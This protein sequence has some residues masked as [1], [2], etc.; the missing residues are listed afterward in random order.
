MP[1]ILDAH[2]LHAIL[3]LQK[4]DAANDRYLAG[5]TAP[6]LIDFDHNQT[7]I[8]SAQRWLSEYTITLSDKQIQ[9][10]E[11]AR[12]LVDLCNAYPDAGAY[13]INFRLAANE[14]IRWLLAG[15]QASQR[16][17]NPETTQAHLG[18][19]GLAFYELGNFTSAIQYFEDALK[20]AEQIGDQFHQGAWLG[21]LGNIYSMQGEYKK[22]IEYYERHLQ[23]AREIKDERGEGHALA[24]LGVSF[25]FLGD[26][27]KALENYHQ[28][29]DLAVRRGDRRDESQALLNI[30]LA[31]Y[32]LGELDQANTC[33]EAALLI[34]NEL[35]DPLTQALAMGGLADIDID[36][37]VFHA[38]I[39][40]LQ[41]ALEILKNIHHDVGTELR[42]LQ[43]L[44]NAYNACADY[45]KALDTYTYQQNLAEAVGA[46]ASI[47]SALAN[48]ASIHRQ[49][50]NLSLAFEFGEKGL[51]LAEEINSISYEAFIRW[52][53]G[54]IY[55]LQ[56]EKQKAIG[57]MEIAIHIEEQIHAFDLA[58]HCEHLKQLKSL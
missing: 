22:A 38:A 5:E 50:G 16:L 43:S 12:A 17:E 51:A 27:A 31:Y 20:L 10:D 26:T 47:C 35:G 28:F 6:A 34:A 8:Q 24:N 40:T 48:Q 9:S 37:K 21:D 39:Q 32:D 36:Q 56:D 2:L 54:L 33:L 55:E 18:N 52:Q 45:P 57:E 14:R 1:S 53:L 25:A 46:K 30:G 41:N 49:V 19:L 7:N 4:L 13:L 42:L 3:F 44:G 23:I 29:R 15:L 11:I 58:N